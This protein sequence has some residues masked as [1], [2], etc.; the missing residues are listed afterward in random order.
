M[1]TVGCE[2]VAVNSDRIIVLINL[3]FVRL[4]DPKSQLVEDPSSCGK[5]TACLEKPARIEM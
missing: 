3:D 2:Y 1:I 4:L 5:F